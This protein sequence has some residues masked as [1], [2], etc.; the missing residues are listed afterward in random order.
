MYCQ[1]VSQKLNQ[2]VD[3]E[4][5]PFE[6]HLVQR[7]LDDC[8]LCDRHLSELQAIR[9]TLSSPVYLPEG[10][11]KRMRHTLITRTHRRWSDYPSLLLGKFLTALRDLDRQAALCRL[12]AFPVSLV[13]LFVLASQLPRLPVQHWTF[14]VYASELDSPT[15]SNRPPV[16]VQALQSNERISEL[17]DTAWRIPY[18]DSFS[19]VAEISPEGNA[20]IENVLEYPRTMELLNAVDLTLQ[21]SQ[22]EGTSEM[23]NAFLIYSFQKVDVYEGL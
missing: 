15:T 5:S 2:F 6:A 23:S 18:E 21:E 4:M 11:R 9:G 1:E 10:S 20:Q 16:L 13:L 12:S 3:G 14:P 8:P 19:L 17:M 7:H 22:F